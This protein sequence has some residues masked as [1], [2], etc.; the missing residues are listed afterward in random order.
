[1]KENEYYEVA[2]HLLTIATAEMG[3]A[4]TLTDTILVELNKAGLKPSK[5]FVKK[6]KFMMVHLWC[7]ERLVESRSCYKKN[8]K[9]HPLFY[10]L[11]P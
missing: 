3:Y 6:A 9:K 7:Q 10:P 5:I 1:M 11:L 2:E 8:L 4:R